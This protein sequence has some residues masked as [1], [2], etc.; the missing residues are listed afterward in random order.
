MVAGLDDVR[1]QLVRVRVRDR[2]LGS[3]RKRRDPSLWLVV[4]IAIGCTSSSE[5]ID[6]ASRPDSA[7]RARQDSINRARPDYIVDSIFP[8]DE[9]LRRFRA[10]LGGDSARRFTGGSV[11]RGALVDRFVKAIARSDT[12]EI[13][14]MAVTPREFTDLYYM[15][16]PYSRPPYRQQP[17]LAWTM[18]QNPSTE[19]LSKLLREMGARPHVYVSHSC[20]AGVVTEG[21]TRRHSGCHVVI[22]EG[23]ATGAPQRLFGTILERDGQFKFLSYTNGR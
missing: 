6:T 8:T 20:D 15:E 1:S 3:S 12:T 5:R 18:I 17:K 22:R 4:A 10:E 23:A 14:A 19:D 21:K 16:S 7:A 2:R 9:A 13:R 11:S